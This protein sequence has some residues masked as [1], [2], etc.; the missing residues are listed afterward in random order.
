MRRPINGSDCRGWP[1]PKA[2][3]AVGS[4][5]VADGMAFEGCKYLSV[6]MKGMKGR[7]VKVHERGQRAAGA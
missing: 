7:W 4:V 3:K 6:T 2:P 5:S 1:A